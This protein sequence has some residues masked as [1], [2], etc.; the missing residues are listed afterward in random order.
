MY[1]RAENADLWNRFW[2]AVQDAAQRDG[3]DLP[4]LTPPE[5][6]P[7]PWTDHWLRDDLVLS[8]T[9]G[10]PFRT[11][12]KNRV[13]YV[14]TLFFGLNATP[15]YYYS[16]V[17]T[18]SDPEPGNSLTLAYNSSDSQSGWAAAQPH[19]GAINHYLE[20]GSHAASARAVLEGRADMACI[21]A[22]SWRLLKRFEPEMQ[23][24][25][26]MANTPGTPA[27]PLIC[28]KD[29]DPAPLRR[30]IRD[31]TLRFIPKDAMDMGGPMTI[32]VL[33]EAAYHAIPVPPAPPVHD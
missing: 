25:R 16:R 1:W 18:R 19:L 13:T 29:H 30:A 3:I 28:A 15:G 17:I 24:L 7:E 9:C 20:T 10:L 33:D 2:A 31:A 8:M 12:L 4:A 27:L 32:L 22:V 6:I 14:G 23:T 26:V 21:D 5:D 11:A